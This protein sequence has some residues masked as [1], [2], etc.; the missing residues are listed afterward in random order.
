MWFLDFYFKYVFG[1]ELNFIDITRI[2]SF[3]PQ[4]AKIAQRKT[5]Y[6]NN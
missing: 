1:I 6:E 4:K 5:F 3:A 2:N